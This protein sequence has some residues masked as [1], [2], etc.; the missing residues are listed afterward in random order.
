M[1]FTSD[2]FIAKIKTLPPEIDAATSSYRFLATLYVLAIEFGLDKKQTEEVVDVTVLRA[3]DLISDNDFTDRIAKI[4]GLTSEK[5]QSLV[6]KIKSGVL[7][8]VASFA[9][10]A[11]ISSEEFATLVKQLESK[12]IDGGGLSFLDQ[13]LG[14]PSS[15]ST[16]SVPQP[17]KLNEPLPSIQPKELERPAD[18]PQSPPPPSN[19]PPTPQKTYPSGGDPYREPV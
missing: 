1:D 14:E 19:P 8:K 16:A 3:V 9:A 13:K 2:Q 6:S 15:E 11:D 4:S 10:T 18:A 5:A 17:Q 12:Q 7:S